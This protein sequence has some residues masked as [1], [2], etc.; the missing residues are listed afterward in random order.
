MKRINLV[1]VLILMTISGCATITRGKAAD[2]EFITTPAGAQ[3]ETT[4]GFS[5][6]ST[7]CKIKVPRK[8][9]FV[10]NITKAGCT[11]A[12]VS[13]TNKIAGQGGAALA[14]NIF[15]GGIIGVGVDA[16]TGASLD[17]VPNPVTVEL[18]CR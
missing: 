17:L 3:V 16:A 2:L 4:N 13:V 12:A 7:P 1:L 10:A 5:C 8:S 6:I 18:S 11:P 14:G 15:V 9:E